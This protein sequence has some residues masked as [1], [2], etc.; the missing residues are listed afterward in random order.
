MVSVRMQVPTLAS[1]RRLRS[2]HCHKLWC[3]LQTQLGSDMAVAVV[4]A[5]SYSS[6]WIPTLGTFIC[7][8]CSPE[9]NKIKRERETGIGT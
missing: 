8:G 7:H 1:L 9:K 2:Q 5:N 6:D 3:M 4:W